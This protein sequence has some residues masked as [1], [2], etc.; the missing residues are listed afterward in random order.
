LSV[1][2]ALQFLFPVN[3]ITAQVGIDVDDSLP[4]ELVVNFTTDRG[5]LAGFKKLRAEFRTHDIK[6]NPETPAAFFDPNIPYDYTPIN[7]ESVAGEN[8]AW[9]GVG[10]LP[11]VGFIVCRRS[12]RRR[13]WEPDYYTLKQSRR[14]IRQVKRQ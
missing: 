5:L 2:R 12:R 4:V 6:W 10:T 14:R 7:L 8:A 1:P 13:R 3:D 11:I 9:L